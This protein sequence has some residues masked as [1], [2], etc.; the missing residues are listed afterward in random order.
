[1]REKVVITLSIKAKGKFLISIQMC[2]LDA[3][4]ISSI[5]LTPEFSLL[6][7][8]PQTIGIESECSEHDK[9]EIHGLDSLLQL[10]TNGL[11]VLHFLSGSA[12]SCNSSL[13][14]IS[15]SPS[16]FLPGQ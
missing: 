9:Y 5:N 2:F 7:R 12:V 13:K 10:F 11:N 3:N 15:I 4:N 16:L 14:S 6:T 1:M 8:V